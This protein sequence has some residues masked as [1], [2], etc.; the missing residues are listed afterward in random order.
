MGD[1]AERRV[2]FLEVRRLLLGARGEAV[3]SG[4]YS[5]DARVDRVGRGPD[6]LHGALELA[7]RIVEIRL[8]LS[9]GG[10]DV[11]RHPP[12]K[13]LF[14]QSRERD[15]DQIVD[16]LALVDDRQRLRFFR[17]GAS[18]FGRQALLFGFA[19]E[20]RLVDC[21]VAE[22]EDRLGHAPISSPRSSAGTTTLVSP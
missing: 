11:A 1:L 7:D 19:L 18:A 20:A 3:R 9:I 6:V 17:C 13:V 12:R 15:A 8:K 10:R 21:G 14:R 5:V 22:E 16:Q 4:R 2:G